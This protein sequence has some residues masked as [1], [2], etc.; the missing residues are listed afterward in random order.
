MSIRKILIVDDEEDIRDILRRQFAGLGRE[1]ETAGSA[2]EALEALGRD[3][4]DVMLMDL[5]MPDVSGSELLVRARSAAPG[6]SI[7]VLTGYAGCLEGRRLRKLGARAVLSKPAGIEVLTEVIER[8]AHGAA[9]NG[10]GAEE[11]AEGSSA[12]DWSGMGMLENWRKA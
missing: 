9:D 8:I 1:V 6:T 10:D 11:V 3:S 2:A 7:V 12:S 4:F 5:H